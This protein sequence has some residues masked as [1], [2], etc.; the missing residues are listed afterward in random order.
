MQTESF[1]F[2]E[3]TGWSTATLPSLDSESTLVLAFACAGDEQCG[4]GLD[5]LVAAHPKSHVLACSTAGE[6]LGRSVRDRSVAVAVCRFDHTRLRSACVPI[7]SSSGSRAA[8]RT[9]GETLSAPDLRGVFVLSDGIRVNGSELVQGLNASLP[10]DTVVTGGLAGDGDRFKDTWVMNGTTRGPG[11]VCAVGFY[12]DRIL[13]GH[14]S[15]GGWD[16]F[17]PDRLVTRSS[18]NVL[19][20]IDGKPALGIYKRYLGALAS[21]LPANALL[22]PLG[23]RRDK[24]SDVSV[25]RTILSIDEDVGSMTFAGD[26]PEGSLVRFMRANFDRLVDGANEAGRLSVPPGGTP[27]VAVAISCVGRRLV[28]GDRAEEEVEA[29]QEAL[30]RDSPLVGFYS[31][32]EISPQGVARCDLHNQTMTVTTIAETL[33]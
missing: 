20:E 27:L 14:G 2:I 17:G 33:F 19:Y 8:G 29:V 24:A 31:Y 21:G 6:I 5:Q 25:V 4:A 23:L 1:S 11:Y 22:F 7:L 3:S 30:P 9:I 26:V 28:L 10:P 15:R 18:G 13:L 16:V 32:G 12:G